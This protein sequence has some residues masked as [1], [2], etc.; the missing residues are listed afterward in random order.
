VNL[1]RPTGLFVLERF[2]LLP[3]LIIA[4]LAGLGVVQ[5]ADWATRSPL[6]FAADP[7]AIAGFA[8]IIV[9][10][11]AGL[12]YRHVDLSNDRVAD[13]YARDILNGL[14]K[15]DILLAQGD[16]SIGPLWAVPWSH[17][18]CSRRRG[19]S[20]TF[21]RRVCR[22]RPPRPFSPSARPMRRAR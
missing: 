5:L 8:L 18:T 17:P 22:C 21:G 2:F 6:R 15:D 12:N 19:T 9:A 10:V 13:L 16:E 14:P 4:P 3:L 1:S 20:K 11:V 7:R